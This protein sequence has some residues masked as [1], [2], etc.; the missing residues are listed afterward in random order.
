MRG[1]GCVV[2]FL[3]RLTTRRCSLVW[4]HSSGT[5]PAADRAGRYRAVDS[6]ST[7]R[8]LDSKEEL[9]MEMGFFDLPLWFYGHRACGY[10]EFCRVSAFVDIRAERRF[11]IVGHC[12]QRSTESRRLDSRNIG[13]GRGVTV[14]KSC[15]KI[16]VGRDWDGYREHF[17]E[18]Q[19][20]ASFFHATP[21][22]EEI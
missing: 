5:A 15:S 7:G 18:M 20:Q 10:R 1:L 19:S 12:G 9:I 14:G 6:L 4:R 16:L 13:H 3:R 21:L 2:P 11:E 22:T 17:F 8:Y